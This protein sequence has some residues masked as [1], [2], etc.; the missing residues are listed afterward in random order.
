M[1]HPYMLIDSCGTEYVPLRIDCVHN[2]YA[3]KITV[4]VCVLCL[5]LGGKERKDC[6]KF[7]QVGP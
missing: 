7:Y 4:Y 1:K 3:L 2:K 6:E 5:L